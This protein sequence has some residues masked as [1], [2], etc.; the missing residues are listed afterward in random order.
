[1]KKFLAILLLCV[2]GNSFAESALWE[3]TGNIVITHQTTS[4]LHIRDESAGSV[5]LIVERQSGP[6]IWLA[7]IE[8]SSAPRLD[9]V[10]A[11][12][13]EANADVG[14]A[15]DKNNEGR[16]QLSEL[17]YTHVLS[18]DGTLSMGFI[19]VSGFFE[20]SRVAS[21]ETTQFLGAFFVGNPTI[22]FPD[23]TLG[24]VY[25]AAFS[26]DVVMRAAIA[27]SDGLADNPERSYS[28]LLSVDGSEGIFGIASASWEGDSWL[29]RA[30]AWV[31]SAD[32]QTLNMTSDNDANYGAYMLAGYKQGE[33]S[34]NVRLGIANPNVSQADAFVSAA[35]R[36]QRGR[37]TIGAA[38]GRAF[39]SSKEPSINLGDTDQFELFIRYT[40][41]ENLFLTGDLQLIKNSHYGTLPENRNQHAN[42]Y[43]AR[44]TW[45]YE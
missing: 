31:N 5:D 17:Y 42:V 3:V 15:L 45:L 6:G 7:H 36:Y 18:G 34:I 25:Q 16:I 12:L 8:A 28:Q 9:R 38:I 27:S 24:V 2:T 33:H 37:Y 43:G 1:M 32:H 10:S 30:G 14:S 40:L 29:L 22:E 20:Q 19:D 41:S 35:Y 4:E 44:L 13:P 26:R 21:D 23:Y 11:I 39:L